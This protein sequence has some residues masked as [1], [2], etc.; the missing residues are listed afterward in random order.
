MP[1]IIDMSRYLRVRKT[2][3]AYNP[4]RIN[5]GSI[6]WAHSESLDGVISPDYVVFSC[7]PQIDPKWVFSYLKSEHGLQAINLET[8][9]SV[10]ERLYFNALSRVKVPLPPLEEQRQ[11]VE[12]L[13]KV[14]AR[15]T[16]ASILRRHSSDEIQTVLPGA[17]DSAI[18]RH[19]P[20]VSLEEAVD[21]DRPITYGIVQAG[22]ASVP[23]R[24]RFR[25]RTSW[26]Q[27]S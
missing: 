1:R 20:V 8:A 9:G 5:V 19:W 16:E 15:I 4:M 21:P 3:F 10:R 7:R 18:G 23:Q 17:V 11:I 26:W 24:S 14:D 25:L 22:Q 13:E 6:G 2:W 27:A 12:K